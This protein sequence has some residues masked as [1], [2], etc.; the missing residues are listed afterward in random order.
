MLRRIACVTT[1]LSKPV[2]ATSSF[3]FPDNSQYGSV[4]SFLCTL[5]V[6]VLSAVEFITVLQ[7]RG[8]LLQLSSCKVQNRRAYGMIPEPLHDV[9]WLWDH[10]MNFARWQHPAWDTGQDLLFVAPLVRICF[11]LLGHI[12]E[13]VKL[14]FVTEMLV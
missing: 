6:T 1:Q 8:K 13:I 11:S 2:Y 9:Q 10:A 12:Y 7:H 4:F 14:I 5:F 3:S